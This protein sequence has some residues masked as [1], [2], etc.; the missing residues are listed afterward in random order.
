MTV[1]NLKKTYGQ[2]VVLD[3]PSFT[4][5]KGSIYA[6]VGS[7]GC[8]KSTFLK[9]LAGVEKPDHGSVLQMDDVPKVGYNPQINYSFKMSVR[10][11]I[12]L[13]AKD[14][15]RADKLMEALDI[16]DLAKKKATHLSG[17]E[18]ARM[19]LCRTLMAPYDLLLLDEPTA[20]MDIRSTLLS[21][22]L[23][24]RYAGETGCTVLLVTHSVSSAARTAKDILFL[25]DGHIVEFGP[26]EQVL[27]NP[28]HRATKE[29][30]N[31]FSV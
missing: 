13:A 8:G 30:L 11:N 29:F 4:F 22:K 19:T 27:H 14:P 5:E 9:I 17:G 20:A 1:T 26:T 21:E 3:I 28:Q 10:R 2:R 18:T 25:A 7:N 16:K 31:F 23:I 24:C 12:Q 15:V 6:I